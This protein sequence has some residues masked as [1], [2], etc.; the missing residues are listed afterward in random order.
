MNSAMDRPD[1]PGQSHIGGDG[2]VESLK[3]AFVVQS[4]AKSD[5]SALEMTAYRARVR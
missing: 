3:Y 1:A 4:P 5:E 2:I